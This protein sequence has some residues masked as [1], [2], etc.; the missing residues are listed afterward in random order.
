MIH[1]MGA[2][3]DVF[4]LSDGLYVQVTS[5]FVDRSATFRAPVISVCLTKSQSPHFREPA[6][7]ASTL[8]VVCQLIHGQQLT[9]G[10]ASECRPPM[11]HASVSYSRIDTCAPGSLAHTSRD[12][13][14]APGTSTS[15]STSTM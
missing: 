15:T 7:F 4:V 1:E 8:L 13:S 3:H 2:L 5:N 12:V 10:R 6:C 14:S 9:L 11:L